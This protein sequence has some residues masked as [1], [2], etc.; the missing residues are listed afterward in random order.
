MRGGHLSFSDDA[1]SI[2]NT[3]TRTLQ[4]KVGWDVLK[5]FVSMRLI[6]FQ[7]LFLY[8]ARVN[9]VF[10]LVKSVSYCLCSSSYI[11]YRVEAHNL[12]LFGN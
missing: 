12:P 6:F 11:I 8:Y 3:G 5:V 2:T 4:D 7:D 9:F 1:K 10:W